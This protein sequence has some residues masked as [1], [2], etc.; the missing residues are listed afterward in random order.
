MYDFTIGLFESIVKHGLSWS[1][2]AAVLFLILKQRAMKRK[3]K[4]YL[5]FMFKEEEV[6]PTYVTNQARI[7]SKL[8]AIMSKEGIEWSGP[9]NQTIP[10]PTNSRTSYQ[11]SWRGH[12]MKEYLKKLGRTKF[13]AFLIL[14]ISN[15][16]MLILFFTGSINLEGDLQ[17]YMPVINI[18]TQ[19]L[20]SGI[21][22]WVEGK[23]D[24]ARAEKEPANEP[25]YTDSG[26][27]E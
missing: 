16:T 1:T 26:P 19:L 24:T 6:N 18:V 15:I 9:V 13:Q 23:I 17:I 8:D 11:F 10:I 21:Y 25:A 27:A 5:P 4:R 7:E 12:I 22:I 14:T 2:A 3:L 20:G